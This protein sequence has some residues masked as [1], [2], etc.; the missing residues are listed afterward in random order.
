MKMK[1]EKYHGT[2][3]DFIIIDDRDNEFPINEN[4]INKL[5]NRHFG[6]GADGLLLLRKEDRSDF[7]MVYFNSDGKEATFCGNGGRCISAFAHTLGIVDSESNFAAKD[8]M[9]K[10]ILTQISPDEWKVSLS[11]KDAIIYSTDSE[12]VYLNTGTYHV[13][14]FVNDPDDIDIMADGPVIRYSDIYQPQGTNVNFV[15]SYGNK[16]R[17]R[18]YEKGVE[19]ETLSCGTGV[20]A[21]AIATSIR[22]GGEHFFVST[23]GGELEVGFTHTKESFTNIRLIGS[24]VRVFE[25]TIQIS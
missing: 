16:I 2:G 13:V 21:A 17:V 1:F 7:R 19:A 18:T 15:S 25:G 24:A 8:G 4:I 10:A 11:M 5:C 6:I 20:T 3:N 9:H 23:R 22:N 14:K 12:S